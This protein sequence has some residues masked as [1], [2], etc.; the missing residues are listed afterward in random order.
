[1][2]TVKTPRKTSAAAAAKPLPLLERPGFEMALRIGTA[3]LMA[4][5]ATLVLT[6][7]TV[8]SLTL[9][10]E[11]FARIQSTACTFGRC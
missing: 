7:L 10:S 8:Y 5:A 4:F 6:H 3:T 9:T 2:K 1:M 11:N